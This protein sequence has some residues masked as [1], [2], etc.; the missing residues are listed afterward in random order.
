VLNILNALSYMRRRII[1]FISLFTFGS[2]F[3]GDI[4]RGYLVPSKTYSPD[5]HYGVTVPILGG[6]QPSGDIANSLIDLR[7]GRIIATISSSSTGWSRQNRGGVLPSR[8]SP[9]G[10]ILLWEV[11]GR[12]SPSA[13][14]ILSIEGGRV[15][16]QRNLLELAQQAI[17]VRTRK[18]VPKKYAAAKSWN[19]GSGAA[20]PDGFTVNVRAEGD[21]E[22]G[23]PEEDV[24]GKPVSLPLKIHAELTSNPKRLDSCPKE[25]QLDS[26]L[27]AVVDQQGRFTVSR[28]HLRDEPFKHGTADS[29]FELTNPSAAPKAPAEYGDVVTLKGKVAVRRAKDGHTTHILILVEKMSVPASEDY[30]TEK[31]VSEIR[32]LGFDRW[33][34]V[35]PIQD[36]ET[37]TLYD[38][39]GTLG[40]AKMDDQLP[41]ITL[42]VHGYGHGGYSHP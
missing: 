4:P 16:W 17:L 21:K 27:D 25:A 26:E 30:P 8:W 29:W 5:H 13:L 31:N 7:T 39:S 12:F 20:F 6:D 38:I 41:T 34:E 23:G 2:S 33:A 22:R 36:G 1:L 40:H 24:K 9:D 35:D 3:A 37:G 15:K 28:F 42:N 18:A 11:E 14:T 19:D 32:L 10:S